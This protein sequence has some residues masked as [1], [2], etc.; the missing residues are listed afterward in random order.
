MSEVQFSIADPYAEVDAA[1]FKTKIVELGEPV[2]TY[3]TKVDLEEHL[4]VLAK[5]F[6]KKSY[7]EYFHAATIVFIRRKLNIVFCVENFFKMWRQEGDFLRNNL[8]S[9][10]LVSACDTIID[11]SSDPEDVATALS[12]VLL[13][14]TVKLY[15]T[16][17]VLCTQSNFAD[18][19]AN[20][21]DRV[22]LFDGM[23][24]FKIGSGDMIKKM[25]HRVNTKS[26]SL[27]SAPILKE[28][29]NRLNENDT[30]YRRFRELHYRKA[31]YW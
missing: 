23:S 26:N 15:E 10:W 21:T 5:E 18:P 27:I 4:T 8:D 11:H 29:I 7:L 22:N 6:S 19:A 1:L 3:G 14:N 17:R 13:M 28:L 25:I 12:C 20:L 31:T 30:V 24:A 9:R 16:E 2:Y